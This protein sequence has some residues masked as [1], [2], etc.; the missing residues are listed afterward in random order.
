MSLQELVINSVINEKM[1]NLTMA[2]T[3]KI[4]IDCIEQYYLKKTFECDVK[5]LKTNVYNLQQNIIDNNITHLEIEYHY[6]S[7]NY[8]TKLIINKLP[9][10]LKYLKINC[11]FV[12]QN[13]IL[14]DNN[15]ILPESL[16]YC[17]IVGGYISDN[18]IYKFQNL[19]NLKY[20]NSYDYKSFI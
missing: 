17:K 9:L 14:F 10:N 3:S 13:E 5:F 15:L 1:K 19:S 8:H 12:K 4:S 20:F 2:E 18:F 6:F 11:V 7:A 16:I